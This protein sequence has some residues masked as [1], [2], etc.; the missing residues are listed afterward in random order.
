MSHLAKRTA[1]NCLNCGTTV[2]GRYC[3]NCGQENVEPKES[4]WQLVSHFFEDITHF[5]GKFFSTLK[6]LLFKPGFLSKEY[7]NGRRMSYLNPIR[8]YLFTSFIFFLIFFSS[9]PLDEKKLGDNISVKGKTMEQINAMPQQDFDT[10]TKLLNQGNAMSRHDFNNYIDSVKK[11]GGIHFTGHNYKNKAEYDSVLS[12]GIKKHNWVERKIIYK[13]I[14]LNQKYHNNQQEEMETFLKIFMHSFP[15]ML[16]ISLPFFALFFKLL[17]I[18]HKN[19][20]YVS[21]A[22]FVI[23]FYIFVFIAMLLSLGVSGMKSLTGWNWL[24]SIKMLITLIVFFY[25]YKAMRNFYKQTRA[26]TIIKYF[27]LLFSFVFIVILLFTVFFFVS[28]FQV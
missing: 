27:I 19:F 10:F 8:M 9:F 7:M 1:N 13:E 17:Y 23:H 5:D 14:Q 11:E 6:D 28:F 15:Q 12:R 4:V 16:F 24:N 2:V 20:Y 18:R 21:H 25:F 26:K 22:I 3:H